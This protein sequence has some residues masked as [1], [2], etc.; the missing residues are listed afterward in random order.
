MSPTA[1]LSLFFR[2]CPQAALVPRL[3]TVMRN[4]ALAVL[5]HLLSMNV[6]LFRYFRPIGNLGCKTRCG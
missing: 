4:F 1:G 2:F 6:N 5:L 3:H